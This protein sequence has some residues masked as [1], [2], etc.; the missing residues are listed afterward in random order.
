MII[1]IWTVLMSAE[2]KMKVSFTFN[3]FLF[4]F[5]LLFFPLFKMLK[6][7]KPKVMAGNLFNYINQNLGGC[8][9]LGHYFESA[10]ERKA[11]TFEVNG[12]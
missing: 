5:L 4:F 11:L 2:R 3:T 1:K 8:H 12:Q 7:S 9:N 6:K 10:S